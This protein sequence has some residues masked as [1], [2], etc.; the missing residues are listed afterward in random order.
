MD[1]CFSI[2]NVARMAYFVSSQGDGSFVMFVALVLVL[3]REG[4]REAVVEAQS[5]C[6][7]Y[8]FIYLRRII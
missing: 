7:I 2:L 5:W 1:L 4:G 3:T 6:S 8:C